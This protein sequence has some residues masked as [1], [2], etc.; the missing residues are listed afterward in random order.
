M[1]SL[2][3]DGTQNQLASDALNQLVTSYGIEYAFRPYMDSN[4]NLLT[5][6]DL[7]Y[8]ALG[9]PYPASGLA[10]TFPGNLLDYHFHRH[11]IDRRE[12][13]DRHC[14]RR[15][16]PVAGAPPPPPPSPAPRSTW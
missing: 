2:T 4:G 6:V 1:D 7:G 13:G 3:F 8:P 9:L 5:N 14:V 16:P 12:P 15:H 10:Y 11:R